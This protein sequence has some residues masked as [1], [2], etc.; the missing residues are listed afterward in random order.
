MQNI[1]LQTTQG[2]HFGQGDLQSEAIL[3]GFL[4]KT[5]NKPEV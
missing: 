1:A 2:G 4:N 5:L 3:W